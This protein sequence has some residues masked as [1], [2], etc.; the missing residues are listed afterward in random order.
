M[1]AVVLL[2]ANLYYRALHANHLLI[3]EPYGIEA[4]NRLDRY[5]TLSDFIYVLVLP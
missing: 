2:S 5:G 4:L 1:L 3:N